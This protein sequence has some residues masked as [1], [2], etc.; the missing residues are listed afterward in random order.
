MRFANQGQVVKNCNTYA[1][2]V[3]FFSKRKTLFQVMLRFPRFFLFA[4]EDAQYIVY[5]GQSSSIL[6]RFCKVQRLLSQVQGLNNLTSMMSC[7]TPVGINFRT[8]TF[9]PISLKDI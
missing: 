9:R 2:I 1:E 5:L 4:S 8:F 7:Q 6:G 3:E